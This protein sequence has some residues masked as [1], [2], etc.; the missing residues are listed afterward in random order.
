MRIIILSAKMIGLIASLAAVLAWLIAIDGANAKG[1]ARGSSGAISSHGQD[2][3]HPR[4]SKNER[5]HRH[6]RHEFMVGTLP[7]RPVYCDCSYDSCP[8]WVLVQCVGYRPR[9][10]AARPVEPMPRCICSS[11]DL[12]DPNYD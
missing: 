9:H 12:T 5:G 3:I 2:T 7:E 11:P 4:V 10:T 8:E 1:H 6:H